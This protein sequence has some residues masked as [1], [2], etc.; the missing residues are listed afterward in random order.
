MEKTQD[1]I[2]NDV[3]EYYAGRAIDPSS[4]CGPESSYSGDKFYDI[5]LTEEIPDNVAGF[6]MGCG[7][8]ISYAELK[9]GEWVLDLGS[10]GGLDCF[11]A[12]KAVG[13]EGHVIG[14]DMT[15][16][17]LVRARG[18]ADKLGFDNVEFRKGLLEDMPV[19]DGS[20]DVV[21]SNCVINLSP[22]KPAVF[23][24]IYRT[25]KPGGRISISDILRNGEFPEE[26]LNDMQS[27]SAC[28]AGALST[29]EYTQGLV[30]AGFE[31]IEIS[32]KGDAGEVIPDL[33]ENA[34]FSGLIRA[35]KLA[36]SY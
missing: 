32:A 20:V 14:I 25:L 13:K 31:E 30:E 35:R 22:D 28:E 19:D 5:Q 6:S 2:R 23:K 15:P 26:L 9:E 8:P 10:G 18:M 16:E 4:C 24:E 36:E 17:M 7:D 3:Q 33:P 21:I 34:A 27:W 12:A 29:E 11:L 1:E